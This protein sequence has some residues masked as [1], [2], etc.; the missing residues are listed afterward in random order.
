MDIFLT[1]SMGGNR[2]RRGVKVPCA[3]DRRNHFVD[4]LRAACGLTPRVMM[5][6]STPDGHEINDMYRGLFQGAFAA[7]GF[8]LQEL[9]YV[10]DR[11]PE[12]LDRIMDFDLIILCGGHVPTQNAYFHSIRLRQRLEN[13]NGTIV[14]I[15]AGTM[16]AA[17][18]VY[19]QPELEGEAADPNFARYLPG[20]GLTGINVLPHFR[21]V[22]R[23]SV[24]GCNV[25]RQ[26]TIPDSYR[27]PI[28]AL[29]DGSYIHI[30]KDPTSQGNR[31]VSSCC[32]CKATVYG[33]SWIFRDG[34]KRRLCWQGRS[35]LL[36]F[37]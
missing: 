28:I 8:Q 1:S 18:T 11:N 17:E 7:S 29:N 34:V 27:S 30:T 26:L 21:D 19:A 4:K 16:N 35:R 33:A 36:P 5:I 22:R 3:F 6:C 2:Q 12:Q 14:G 23:L 31:V 13:W 9:V 24:D 15:S 32:K 37:V 20:L 10:D 25:E